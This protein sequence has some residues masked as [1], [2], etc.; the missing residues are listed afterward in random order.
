[1]SEKDESF[2]R[3]IDAMFDQANDFIGNVWCPFRNFCYEVVLPLLF[4][5]VIVLIFIVIFGELRL[6]N[7]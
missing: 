6:I 5:I 3:R 1:M 4:V 2:D 7:P